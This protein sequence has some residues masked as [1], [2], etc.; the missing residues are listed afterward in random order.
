[1]ALQ[2]DLI[3]VSKWP[4]PTRGMH[5]G[6]VDCASAGV[7]VEGKGE[8]RTPAAAATGEGR[9]GRMK[10]AAAAHHWRHRRQFK[11]AHI[12][13]GIIKGRSTVDIDL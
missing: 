11:H 5:D 8:E 7:C 1:M 9:K 10:P 3:A 13:G 6:T 2:E 4:N 12:I